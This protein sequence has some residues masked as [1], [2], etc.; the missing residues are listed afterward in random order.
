MKRR[1]FVCFVCAAAVS[2]LC[3]SSYGAVERSAQ[4]VE[5]GHA[6]AQL[7]P[8]LCYSEGEG[9]IEDCVEAYK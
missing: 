4:A 8:G 7:N 9:V 6:G 3:V 1:V 2:L 5:Q